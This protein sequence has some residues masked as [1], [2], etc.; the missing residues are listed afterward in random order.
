[1]SKPTDLRASRILTLH[2]TLRDTAADFARRSE[3]IAREVRAKRY[4]AEQ[5]HLQHLQQLDA[6]TEAQIAEASAQWQAHLDGILARHAARDTACQRYQ[7][8]I[9]R[10]LPA[11]MQ[12]ERERWLGKQQVRRIQAQSKLKRELANDWMPP[13]HAC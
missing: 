7:H 13:K 3:T 1:V 11:M 10:D 9:E 4:T 5:N 8:R 2:N 12:K 6:A